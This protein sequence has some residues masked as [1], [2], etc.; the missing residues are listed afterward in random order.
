MDE[1]T[2][3]YIIEFFNKR[4]SHFK[5][6][7]E[8]LGWTPSGQRLR[9]E[10]VLSLINPEGFSILDFGCGRGDF[11]GFLRE[12][13]ISCS[14]VGVDINPVLI[15][16]AKTKYPEAEFLNIDIEEVSLRKRFDYT[17]AIGVFNL[18]VYGV[19]ESMKNCIR[20]LFE[21]TNK[22]L[23]F[24]CLDART[25][26]KDIEVVY[27]HPE[28]IKDIISVFCNDFVIY[29]S[30]VEGDLFVVLKKTTKNF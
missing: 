16:Q 25:K 13:N 14:Y 15:K 1:L 3:D 8:A 29:D 11:Y 24:T 2:K 6:S 19:K 27:F 28:E 5:D 18:N 30:L 21:N 23:V 26:N 22:E 12:K 20:I 9:Y 7:P 17:V 4:V 10:K